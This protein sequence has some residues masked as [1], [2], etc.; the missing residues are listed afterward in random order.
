MISKAPQMNQFPEINRAKL[1]GLGL[2]KVTEACR[3]HMANTHTP[4]KSDD[5]IERELYRNQQCQQIALEL[6]GTMC[7]NKRQLQKI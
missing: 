2:A 1:V 5:Y 6:I 3:R 4:G 7:D